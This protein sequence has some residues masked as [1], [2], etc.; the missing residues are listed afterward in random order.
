[1][2]GPPA[3][4]P[5]WAEAASW[6]VRALNTQFARLD[7]DVAFKNQDRRETKT[8]KRFI[9]N[10][11]KS[12]FHRKFLHSSSSRASN[13]TSSAG[14]W[15]GRSLLAFGWE[16]DGPPLPGANLSQWGH[17]DMLSKHPP[18]VKMG[19]SLNS[20]KPLEPPFYGGRSSL[21]FQVPSQACHLQL[22]LRYIRHIC[23]LLRVMILL[24]V[25]TLL[26]V[27]ILLCV[28]GLLRVIILRRLLLVRRLRRVC[29]LS[30][31]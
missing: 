29:N 10:T 26:C 27:M 18:E 13:V 14:T 7:D 9:N 17:F 8:P 1:M 20:E 19:K 12:D 6:N 2:A 3:L 11:I 4:D 25:M 31:R 22:I 23:S 21:C 5:R 24:C 28:S 30:K 15:I 16:A